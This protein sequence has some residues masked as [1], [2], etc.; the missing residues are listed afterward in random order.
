MK[1]FSNTSNVVS[2]GKPLVAPNLFVN[3]AKESSKLLIPETQNSI[4]QPPFCSPCKKRP[5]NTTENNIF[6]S[7]M[8]RLRRL[9]KKTHLYRVESLY[10]CAKSTPSLSSAD[11]QV[12]SNIHVAGLQF[13]WI[14]GAPG[15][16]CQYIV[17]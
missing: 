8:Q 3:N 2:K 13:F 5:N 7:H 15:M 4:A 14:F 17:L 6:H 12:M 16:L 10:A 9:H 11:L 1:G